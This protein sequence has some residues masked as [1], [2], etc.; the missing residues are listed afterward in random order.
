L[1]HFYDSKTGFFRFTSNLDATLITTHFE[2]EDNVIPASNS[3]MGK[4]LFL[5]SIYFEN[6]EYEKITRQM[7][8]N[9]LPTISYPSAYSNWLDL[10]LHFSEENKELAICGDFSQDYA[11]KIKAMYLPNVILAGSKTQSKLPFLK[12]R[13]VSEQNLFYLCQ[14]QTCAAPTT[15]FEAIISELI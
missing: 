5:L 13:F 4:N 7:L 11:K 14:N 12:D 15:D 6:R 2:T 10:A 3:V 8:Q 1:A 9:I